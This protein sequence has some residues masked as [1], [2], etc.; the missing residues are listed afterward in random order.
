M[1]KYFMPDWSDKLD[2]G[3][4]FQT[5]T[6]T[7]NRDVSQD[8]YAHQILT[9]KHPYDGILVSRAVIEKS[10]GSYEEL[11]KYGVRRYF[12]LSEG[13][14]VFGDCG[15]FSYVN[16]DDPWYE[17]EDVINYYAKIG[18]NYG[19]SVDHLIF[20]TIYITETLEDI[21]EDGSIIIRK[22]KRK[23]EMPDNERKRRIELTLHNARDFLRLHRK[24]KYSFTPVGVAQGGEP[25]IYAESVKA[26]MKMGYTYIAIGGLARS[27]ANHILDV[28]KAVNKAVEESSIP[29]SKDIRFH[30]FGVAKMTLLEKL[31]KYRVASIDSASYLRKA[32]LRSGQNYLCANGEWHTAI[33]VPQSSQRRVQDYI[34]T[35]GK[36]LEQVQSQEAYCLKMLQRY[37]DKGL[38]TDEFEHLL[39]A[40]IEYD[41]YLFRAGDDGQK[42]R[43]KKVSK[44]KYRR[45]LE[46]KPWEH[47]NCEIC[48]EIGVHVVIFR[49]TNR[50]KRR[51]FHNTWTFYQRLKNVKD[52]ADE[53]AM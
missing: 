16:E 36:T 1:T 33:R 22:E 34:C 38:S 29:K 27:N 39:D 46:A 24:H 5:D 12:R 25:T 52:R 51:G 40:I 37:N 48:R 31:S 23:V 3:F 42:M 18:A 47:C 7:P 19:A 43:D 49:G 26:L 21:Q 44:E 14:E 11:Q 9:V 35:N 45:T 13:M 6:Y 17:T 8:V 50:N 15:A 32:W 30:L 53:T 20:N 10:K 2:P 4:N 41:T 28:L